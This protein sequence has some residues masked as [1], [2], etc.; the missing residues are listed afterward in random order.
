ML[1]TD[2]AY[3]AGFVDGEGY[4]GISIHRRKDWNRPYYTTQLNVYNTDI[5]A[6]Q[7]M[8][9]SAGVGSIY[10]AH[11]QER[12]EHKIG[13]V[14]R[15]TGLKAIE[16]LKEL[17]PYLKVKHK[18]AELAIRFPADGRS[19][20]NNQAAQEAIREAIKILNQGGKEN[21]IRAL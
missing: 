9:E 11:R 3:I 12:P 4:I 14:W 16:L 21:A 20:H 13:Y 17:L 18:Q 7:S 19:F 1:E 5:F 6:L 8:A 15:T 10:L 2:K